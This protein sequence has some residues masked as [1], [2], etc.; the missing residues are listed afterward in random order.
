MASLVIGSA[1]GYF[2]GPLGFLAGSAI[3]ALLDPQKGPQISD[4]HLQGSTYGAVIPI[5]YGTM[6]VAGQ[7]IWTTEL[8]PHQGKGKGGAGPSVTTYTAS[9]DVLIC[10]GPILGVQRI[11]ADG[12]LIYDTTGTITGLPSLPVVFYTGDESQLPDPTEEA[13]MGA[14]FVPAYRGYAR[15]VFTELDLTN[16]GNSLPRLT[17]QVFSE[18]GQ[19]P[20]RVSNFDVRVGQTGAALSGCS[21][22]SGVITA[23]I[24]FGPDC[25]AS[26]WTPQGTQIGSTVITAYGGNQPVPITGVNVWA[27][28]DP[29]NI[30]WHWGT[31]DPI[32]LA[33]IDL[34]LIGGTGSGPYTAPQQLGGSNPV[35]CNGFIYTIGDSVTPGVLGQYACPSGIP[36]S[37]V[38]SHTLTNETI[39]SLGSSDTG[40]L[41]VLTQ[42]TITSFKTLWRFV[43]G[44]GFTLDTSWN[45]TALAGTH[46]LSNSGNNFFVYQDIVAMRC[47]VGSL[48][49]IGLT[50][51]NGAIL[52]NT[53]TTIPTNSDLDYLGQGL[54]I[55]EI[56][57]FS[58]FPP[59]G[60]VE[61]AVI[62]ADIANRCGLVA[63]QYDVSA[64]TDEV[65]GYLISNQS[66]GRDNIMELRT[67]YFFDAVESSAV[68]NFV[69][70]GGPSMITIPDTD[71]AA[72]IGHTGTPPPL[73]L[74]E[75]TQ[76]V[77]LPATSYVVF[78]DPNDQYL[79]GTQYARRLVT[80]SET[81]STVQLAVALTVQT[82]RAVATLLLFTAWLERNVVTFILSRQYAA[83]EPTDVFTAHGYTIRVTDKT[84]VAGNMIQLKG[85]VTNTGTFI[86]GPGGAVSGGSPGGPPSS[87]TQSPTNLLI[88]NL[89]LIIDTDYAYGP[90]CAMAGA[91]PVL[92]WGG[93]ILYE[94]T[95]SGVTFLEVANSDGPNVMGVATT[96]LGNFTGGNIFDHTNSVTV[97]IGNG[98]GTLASATQLAVLNGA[99]I[100]YLGSGSGSGGEV[101][102]FCTATLI[103]TNTYVLSN[104]LRGRRGTEWQIGQHAA[105]EIFVLLPCVDINGPFTDLGKSR[106]FEALSPG[107]SL[108]AVTPQ[109]FLNTGETL[110]PY[111]PCNIYSTVDGSGNV[112]MTWTRRTRIGGTWADFT[113]VPLSESAEEYVIQIWDSTFTIC[114][115]VI[116]PIGPIP[117]P[118]TG[119]TAPP[120]TYTAAMQTTDF[121][122]L[123]QD[124]YVSIGQLGTFGLGVQ[125]FATLPGGGSSNVSPL[126]PVAPY[127]TGGSSTA[128]PVGCTGTP[129]TGP[130]GNA[131]TW[132]AEWALVSGAFGSSNYWLVTIP[133]SVSPVNGLCK[134][135]ITTYA[136][137]PL[138]AGSIS[139]TLSAVPGCGPPIIPA[140][141]V[142]GVNEVVFNFSIGP[143]PN[144]AT[145][146]QLLAG[147][148]YY[149]AIKTT[150]AQTMQATLYTQG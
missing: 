59:S 109:S 131:F 139:A 84:Y 77:D 133:V 66:T 116:G 48:T 137:G 7:V 80:N 113:D 141:N 138:A 54:G 9:F 98:G 101:I 2:F 105:G 38:S 20:W 62:V 100:A 63:D 104:L 79:N 34:G 108:S 147:K 106:L 57:V 91:S 92:P 71:L 118:V 143:S 3:G 114:A 67:A 121:G 51:I 42:N 86:A 24:P 11:W 36:G 99:N 87:Q 72:Q 49:F 29:A 97:V 39:I 107:Q 85:V 44:S 61:L 142:A 15:A 68:L 111:S 73:A 46:I 126:N 14:G 112:T 45:H 124:I 110:R 119:P 12:T 27:F 70:R 56:G 83:L 47:V 89:P 136:L 26:Q 93:G 76:E 95:D 19:I 140:V 125:T 55:D 28:L 22:A 128:P 5:C 25:Y 35:F 130:S 120:L 50:Q 148:T 13:A 65:P 10:E 90:Y 117:V 17:F 103:A 32:T 41:Y 30:Y 96:A 21:Y 69:K 145:T 102:Q 1:L 75:R 4:L 149:L 52:A 58:L 132:A 6:R 16:Y 37:F 82:A 127:N 33:S 122:Q 129:I 78:I 81:V 144:P 31:I 18:G 146:P 60:P 135:T 134:L 150:V 64:L 74:V 94:S 53:G 115:R 40:Q 23:S 43:A 88:L 123:E 8:H